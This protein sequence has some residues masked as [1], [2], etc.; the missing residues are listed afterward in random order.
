LLS[1]MNLAD[2][3]PAPSPGP[4]SRADLAVKACL[5]ALT[6]ALT[7]HEAALLAGERGETLH[8]YRVAVRRIRSL[9]GQFGAVFSARRARRFQEEFARLARLTSPARD[10]E[11]CAASFSEDESALQAVGLMLRTRLEAARA[12]LLRHVGAVRHQRFMESWRRFLELPVPRRPGRPLARIAIGELAARR[13][14]KLRKRAVRE[15][16]AI[17]PQSP[18][19]ALH[20]LRK[21]C[22]KLRY[23][24][25]FY[26]GLAPSGKIDRLVRDLKA[27]QEIL[28]DY[29][30]GAVHAALLH[31]LAGDLPRRETSADI[32]LALGAR[33]ERER[34]RQEQARAAFHKTFRRFAGDRERYRALF[35]NPVDPA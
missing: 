31:E 16:R 17:G 1:A 35:R 5:R 14:R 3:S 10:L 4:D 26:R 11:V 23:V 12:R 9:L 30:D 2:S 34:I 32:L 18:P 27:L 33:L 6:G 8:D 22:K 19:E 15:G 25:E 29:Q 13:I 24:L 28:G 7:R 20:A 21:T